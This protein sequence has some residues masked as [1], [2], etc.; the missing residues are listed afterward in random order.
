MFRLILALLQYEYIVLAPLHRIRYTAA[1]RIRALGSWACGETIQPCRGAAP[2][3][4]LARGFTDALD[5]REWIMRSHH[6]G[7]A[8]RRLCKRWY[9]GMQA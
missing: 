3:V 7:A 1:L 4:S 9:V 5:M 6:T 2:A 8:V